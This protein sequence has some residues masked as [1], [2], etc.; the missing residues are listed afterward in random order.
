VL[1]LHSTV[2]NSRGYTIMKKTLLLI[3]LLIFSSVNYAVADSPPSLTITSPEDGS[4]VSNSVLIQAE[5][6][7]IPRVRSVRFYIDNILVAEDTTSPYQYIWDATSYSD[8][9]HQIYAS[10]LRA[11]ERPRPLN[12]RNLPVLDSPK[13]TVTIDN[14]PPTAPVLTVSDNTG[15]LDSLTAIWQSEDPESGIAEY[16]YAIG[17]TSLTDVVYW[18]SYGNNTEGYIG[19]LELTNGQYYYLSVVAKNSAG[20]T[21]SVTTSYAIRATKA[22]RISIIYPQQDSLVTEKEVKI[23]GIAEGFEVITING[24]QVSVSEDDTFEGPTLIAPGYAKR[25]GITDTN[26]DYIIM[27]FPGVTTLTAEAGGE[28]DTTS[29]YYYQAFV[30][31]SVSWA[32]YRDLYQAQIWNYDALEDA[33][34]SGWEFATNARYRWKIAEDPSD[35]L[36]DVPWAYYTSSYGY[37]HLAEDLDEVPGRCTS[38]LVIHTPPMIDNAIKPL[39]L[40]LT[41]CEINSYG[42]PPA[43]PDIS[44]YSINSEPLKWLYGN[45]NNFNNCAYV[46]LNSY[47]PDSDVWVPIHIP[48]LQGEFGALKSFDCSNIQMLTLDLVR[49]IPYNSGNYVSVNTIPIFQPDDGKGRGPSLDFVNMPY[50]T[51]MF[52]EDISDTVI[53]TAQVTLKIADAEKTYSLTE[54]TAGSGVFTEPTNFFSL[55]LDNPSIQLNSN[56]QDEITCFVTSTNDNIIEQL[57]NLRES[58]SDSLYFN[59]VKIFTTLIFDNELLSNQQ[60]T[61][62]VHYANGL[63]ASEETLTEITPDSLI[64]T[65]EDNTFT[66]TLNNYSGTMPDNFD[67]TIDNRDCLELLHPRLKLAKVNVSPYVYTNESMDEGSDLSPNDPLNDGQGI[68]KV[69]VKGLPLN[70]SS[71]VLASLPITVTTGIDSKTIELSQQPDKS[72]MTAP[73]VLLPPNDP[74]IYDGMFCLNSPS[75][76]DILKTG[77]KPNIKNNND[78]TKAAFVGQFLW[79]TIYWRTYNIFYPIDRV[80]DRD[81]GYTVTV[82]WKLTK[83]D[84]FRDLP[85]YSVWYSLTHGIVNNFDENIFLFIRVGTDDRPS[86]DLSPQDIREHIENNSYELVFLNACFSVDEKFGSATGA[87]QRAFK[88]K[89]YIGWTIAMRP[90]FAVPRAHKFFRKLDNK[91][92]VDTAFEATQKNDRYAKHLRCL[93]EDLHNVIID[94]TP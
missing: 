14:S 22:P 8:G 36:D 20:L 61:L 62:K 39:I 49:E 53:N 64:F 69:R 5:L 38:G 31:S 13:I 18:T 51:V 56:I 48:V 6:T 32:N 27:N 33:P 19:G 74:T 25:Q 82:D 73:L 30:K 40:V 91:T 88:T 35:T 65:N 9:Q 68:F 24:K 41:G 54:T 85:N 55:K 21:S 77:L 45:W 42:R 89:V 94:K 70:L 23:K 15:S 84:V 28:M 72:Y 11:P 76:E 71:D 90:I 44:L 16:Q 93:G 1:K 66:I 87:F 46:V 58:A 3:F 63:L 60:D 75:G 81:L 10:I 50:L 12:E 37:R 34:F 83:N 80:L 86:Y 79:P 2:S 17:T 57:F 4:F 52:G 43:M 47:T 78:T 26:P 29:F 59:D 7:T 92:P 67:I